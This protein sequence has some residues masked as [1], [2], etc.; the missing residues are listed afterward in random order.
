MIPM[1]SSKQVRVVISGMPQEGRTLPARGFLDSLNFFIAGVYK[2]DKLAYKAGKPSFFFKILEL[3]MNSP[4]SIVMEAVHYNEDL[5]SFNAALTNWFSVVRT[6]NQAES[7]NNPIEYD[8]LE[9]ISALT[10]NIGKY[11][12]SIEISTKEDEFII[13]NNFKTKMNYFLA[14]EEKW[15]GFVQGKL[16]YINIHDKNVFKI[17]PDVG[18][19]KLTCNFPDRLKDEAKSALGSYVEVHGELIFK[20]SA[21]YPH[22]INVDKIEVFPPEESLMSFSEMQIFYA[23]V[24]NKK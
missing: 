5:I 24:I 20:S 9:N 6:I 15:Y 14:K 8:I 11:V 17:Y 7:Y 1:I 4:A 16:D 22:E 19:T 10:K 23:D 2:T 21:T 12:S 3:S 13:D 18:P